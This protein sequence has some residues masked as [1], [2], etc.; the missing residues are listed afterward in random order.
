VESFDLEALRADQLASGEAYLEFLRVPAMS[1]GLYRL[2]A[3]AR[4]AQTPHQQ[5]E[6]YVV[7]EGRAVLRVEDRD[8]P[9]RAGSVA[10]VPAGAE[11]TF[12]SIEE[13]LVALVLFAPAES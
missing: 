8:Q 4:D 9:V 5:D 7:L 11:H 2:G 1:A 3:G 13:D 6:V 12:Q 10:F